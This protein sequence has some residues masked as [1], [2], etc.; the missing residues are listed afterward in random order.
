M[1]EVILLVLI[2]IILAGLF[3]YY[4]YQDTSCENEL[5]TLQNSNNSTINHLKDLESLKMDLAKSEQSNVDKSNRI[6]MLEKNIYGKFDKTS[7][8]NANLNR[9]VRI[10]DNTKGDYTYLQLDTKCTEPSVYNI[11]SYEPN[12][13]QLLV[14]NKCLD[15][16][17]ENDIVV[18]D[19]IITSQ[20]QK[21]DYFPYNGGRIKSSLYSKCLGYNATSN[22]LE[23]QECENTSNFLIQTNPGLW[24]KHLYTMNS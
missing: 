5:T 12:N 9:C 11:F 16:I 1:W 24:S 2:C 14:G 13:K 21:F 4:L 17:N 15:T 8:S 3:G 18:D 10:A 6:T 20:K 22:L 7:L 19:C 23:L